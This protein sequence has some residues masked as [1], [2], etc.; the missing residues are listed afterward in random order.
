MGNLEITF[1]GTGTSQGVPI[2]GCNCEVCCSQEGKDKRLR[3]SVL[4]RSDKGTQFVID[5]GPDFRYQMLREGVQKLDA[6]LITHSHRDHVGGLDDLRPFNYLQQTPMPIYGNAIA[7]SEIRNTYAYAFNQNKYPGLP[8]FNLMECKAGEAFMIKELSV[9]PIEVMHFKLPTLAFRISDF[10]YITD[11]KTIA[12][13]QMKMLYGLDCLVVNTLRKEEH[14]SHFCL[15][16]A[17]ALI[18]QVKPKISY[19]THISHDLGLH[20]EVEPSLPPNVHLAY[21]TLRIKV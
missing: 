2:I 8:Q 9:L 17:L 20:S 18:E 21:D 6:V 10:A 5:A 1:L 19:L 15:S 4:V 12:P 7:V 16:E 3:S 13:S 14:F 11:A